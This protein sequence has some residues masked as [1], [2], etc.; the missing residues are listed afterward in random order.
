MPGCWCAPPCCRPSP[1]SRESSRRPCL[2]SCPPLLLL[3]DGA[4]AAC[5]RQLEHAAAAVG[6]AAMGLWQQEAER[7]TRM[8]IGQRRQRDLDA[9]ACAARR[10]EPLLRRTAA[11]A[12]GLTRRRAVARPSILLVRPAALLDRTAIDERVTATNAQKPHRFAGGDCLGAACTQPCI[13]A[14]CGGRHSG[15]GCPVRAHD[16]RSPARHQAPT[17]P[18][19]PTLFS[20]LRLWHKAFLA[21]SSISLRA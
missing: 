3:R 8:V 7:A 1:P 15:G 10:V 11:A 14:F 5:R 4:A 6:H 19:P 16:R 9:T 13:L 2:A 17:P 20:P 12:A 21:A 18:P